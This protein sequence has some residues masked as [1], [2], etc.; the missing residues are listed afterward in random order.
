MNLSLALV[1]L[2]PVTGPC[3]SFHEES[4]PGNFLWHYFDFIWV[5]IRPPNESSQITSKLLSNK[6]VPSRVGMT[7]N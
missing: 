1:L 4:V 6:K 7:E 3:L 5:R 2:K